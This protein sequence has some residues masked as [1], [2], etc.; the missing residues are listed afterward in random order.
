MNHPQR[1]AGTARR[2]SAGGLSAYLLLGFSLFAVS[3]APARA[4]DWFD[5]AALRGA[6]D[7]GSIS[8]D[9][10]YVGGTYSYSSMDAGFSDAVSSLSTYGISLSSETSRGNSYGGFVGYNFVIEGPLVVGVEGGY[11]YMSPGL[12]VSASDTVSGATTYNATSSITLK[13]Y[14]TLR[15]RVGYPVGRFLPYAQIGLVVGRFSYETSGT[16]TTGGVTSGIL[17][18]A[19]TDAYRA[20]FAAGLGIDVALM[21]NIFLR[22]EYEYIGFAKMGDIKATMNTVRAGLAVKF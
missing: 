22:G 21:S 20:G 14:G 19:N 6:L 11:N 10:F 5:D 13:D 8:W 12:T 2:I 7:D 9:G 3:A 18:N 17:G 15:A 16:S 1:P 4:A